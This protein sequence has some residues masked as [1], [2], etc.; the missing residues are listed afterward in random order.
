LRYFLTKGQPKSNLNLMPWH[1]W[2]FS[3]FIIC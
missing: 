2:A 3:L 1:S